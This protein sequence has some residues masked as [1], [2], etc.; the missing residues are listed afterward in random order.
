MRVID[1]ENLPDLRSGQLIYFEEEVA[2]TDFYKKWGEIS[3]VEKNDSGVGYWV[4]FRKMGDFHGNTSNLEQEHH[5]F[6]RWNRFYLPENPA[7]INR[8]LQ[9][10][11]TTIIDK[12]TNRDIG[13]L[14]LGN[15]KWF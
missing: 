5:R 9:R 15:D 11:M 7:I 6:S 8:L 3:R 2:H 10:Q 12:Y 14:A 1:E 4:I 13:K